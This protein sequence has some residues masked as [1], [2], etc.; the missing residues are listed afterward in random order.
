MKL[1]TVQFSSTYCYF[2]SLMYIYS[3]QHHILKHFNLLS[4]LRPRDKSFTT[5]QN[6][7]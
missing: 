7:T 1:L 5:I 6:N 3:S 4:F 2:L